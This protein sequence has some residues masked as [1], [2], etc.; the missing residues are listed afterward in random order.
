M[1]PDKKKGQLF[2]SY[3][4]HHAG[5]RIQFIATMPHEKSES[6]TNAASR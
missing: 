1:P 3:F 5:W 4:V 2:L 6:G